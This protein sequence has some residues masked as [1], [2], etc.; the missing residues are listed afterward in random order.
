MNGFGSWAEF[1]QDRQQETIQEIWIL[2]QRNK[3]KLIRPRMNDMKLIRKIERRQKLTKTREI[4]R[5]TKKI[6]ICIKFID[7]F[8]KNNK[9]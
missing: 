7:Q 1:H 3:V 8:L 5:K 4:K 6:Q 2:M 9:F